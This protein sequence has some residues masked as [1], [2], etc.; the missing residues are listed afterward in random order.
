MNKKKG[1]FLIEINDSRIVVHPT[2][3]WGRDMD[4]LNLS[5]ESAE[6]LLKALQ[7]AVV[8]AKTACYN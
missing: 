1:Q 5:I 8:E 4:P 3:N 6:S 7:Q 2:D